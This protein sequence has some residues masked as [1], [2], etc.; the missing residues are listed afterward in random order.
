MTSDK[1]V[2]LLRLSLSWTFRSFLS[3]GHPFGGTTVEDTPPWQFEG[4]LKLMRRFN[5]RKCHQCQQYAIPIAFAILSALFAIILQ[6]VWFDERKTRVGPEAINRQLEFY[7]EMA[8]IEPGYKPSRTIGGFWPCISTV[9]ERIVVWVCLTAIFFNSFMAFYPY[10][11]LPL[12]MRVVCL[13]P[14]LLLLVGFGSA[15]TSIGSQRWS[16]VVASGIERGMVSIL[17]LPA[18]GF[19]LVILVTELAS[20]ASGNG[21]PRFGLGAVNILTWMLIGY[22]QLLTSAFRSTSF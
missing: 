3:F 12:K 19:S 16:L 17:Y 10:V 15:F 5:F 13:L 6:L 7:D 8:K 2:T 22:I 20:R 11:V 14:L 18:I 1:V 21:L 4:N 9:P